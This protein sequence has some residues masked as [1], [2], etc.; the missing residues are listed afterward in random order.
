MAW[1]GILLSGGSG[2]RLYPVT[3]VV[4]KQLLPIYNKPMV[5]YSLSVLMLAGIREILLIST[6]HDLP[7]Y[8]E[9]LGDGSPYG[10]RLSYAPQPSPDGL[11]QAFIIGREFIAEDN[12]SLVLGDNILFGHGLTDKLTKACAREVGATV[13]AY[14]VKDP[15]R[16]AVISL[17]D[18]GRPVA[19]EEKPENPGSRLAVPGL[20]FYDNQVVDFARTLRPSARGELE[21]TDVNKRY[22]ERGE[23]AVEMLERGYAWL[24]A[25]TH[26]SLIAASQFVQTVESRQQ[27]MIACLEEIAYNRGW[28]DRETVLAQA[29]RYRGTDYGAHL[30]ALIA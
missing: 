11:A 6:P 15:D 3:S 26:D 27:F 17:D 5:F 12:V 18:A 19:L 25:G 4:S 9:L 10:I 22:L 14:A 20:Y 24:D 2:T 8:R 28:I 7:L 16:F 29:A 30:E 23:L 21:I 13:F 1:K